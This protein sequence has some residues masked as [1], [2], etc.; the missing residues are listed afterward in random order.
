MELHNTTEETI[1]LKGWMFLYGAK[2]TELTAASLEADGYIVLYRSGRDI[3]IDDSGQ[4]MPLDKF[5]ASLANTG[6]ELALFDPSGKGDRPD[7]L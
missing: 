3:H 7:C 2:S 5:P 1:S 6:K 4:D